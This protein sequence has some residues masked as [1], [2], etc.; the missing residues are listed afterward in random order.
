MT[1]EAGRTRFMAAMNQMVKL[2]LAT[3]KAAVA[4]A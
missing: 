2:D 3:L 4:A 1:D